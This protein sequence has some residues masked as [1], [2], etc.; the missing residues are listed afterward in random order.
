MF[1][2][3]FNPTVETLFALLFHPRAKARGNYYVGKKELRLPH[4]IPLYTRYRSY[5]GKTDAYV[6]PSAAWRSGNEYA[7][8]SSKELIYLTGQIASFHSVSQ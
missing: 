3:R 8:K 2:L 1:N 5:D 4:F 7:Q 6:I